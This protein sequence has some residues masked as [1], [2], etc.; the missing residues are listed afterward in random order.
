M[1][2]GIAAIFTTMTAAASVATSTDTAQPAKA[3]ALQFAAVECMTDDGN[4]R[5]RP[6]SASF[7]KDNPNW[8][9]GDE[10]MTDDGHGRKRP[11]SASYKEKHKK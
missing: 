9:G 3:T 10:C 6:C 11:C 4:G 8:R 7:K 2:A 5:K 1:F